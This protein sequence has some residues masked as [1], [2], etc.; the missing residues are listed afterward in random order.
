M[1]GLQSLAQGPASSLGRALRFCLSCQITGPEAID[2]FCVTFA[3]SQHWSSVPNSLKEHLV[4]SARETPP[5]AR[6]GA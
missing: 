1:S 3:E 4:F 5:E 6:G 2:R